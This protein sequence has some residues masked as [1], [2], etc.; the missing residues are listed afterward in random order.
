MFD[1]TW[2]PAEPVLQRENKIKQP[3]KHKIIPIL[4]LPILVSKQHNKITIYID[5]F[6][7]DGIL[8]FL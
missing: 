2:G 5:I 3:Y 8:L 1:I 4:T 7:I 6:Y